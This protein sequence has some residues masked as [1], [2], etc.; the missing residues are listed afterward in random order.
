M[1][2][3]TARGLQA[4]VVAYVGW[5]LLTIYWKQLSGFDAIDLVGWRVLTSAL[6]MTAIVTVS[7]RWRVLI[8]AMRDRSTRATIA[9]AAA[10]LTVNWST[11]V[12]AVVNGHVIETAL[13]YFLAPLGTLAIGVLAYGERLTAYKTASIVFAVAAIVVL[14][15][16][17]GEV[18]WVAILLTLTWCVYAIA[19]RRVPLDPIVSLAGELVVLTPIAVAVVAY[20][21]VRT[22]GLPRV[23]SGFDWPLVI[24]TGLVTALPLM[25]FA[26]AAKRVPFTILGPTNYLVPIIN[27]MLGWLVYD[28]S[29]PASR[30]VGFVLVWIALIVITVEL[31][32]DRQTESDTTHGL[33]TAEVTA[34]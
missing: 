12:W 33:G 8:N 27:F 22:D 13:G 30:V 5:G 25:L 1:D 31:L 17:Y 23:A 10:V 26:F 20:T 24:G 19:K 16:S 9:V 2:R 7:G 14:V 21:F 29:L 15:V 28:E 18:P 6:V 11:Y 32:R 4:A 34:T 3:E